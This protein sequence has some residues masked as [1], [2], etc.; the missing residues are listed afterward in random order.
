MPRDSHHEPPHQEPY[1]WLLQRQ[2]AMS[3]RQF[4]L[5]YAVLCAFSFS[6]A[7]VF[8]SMGVWQILIFT[9]VE[10]S[11]VG[12]A[13]IYHARH[14]ADMERIVLTGD[15]LLVET[16]SAGRP[17][18]I[19]L[20]PG[21]TRVVLRGRG[22]V[23]LETGRQRILVGTMVSEQRRRQCAQELRSALDSPEKNV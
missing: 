13:F 14:A 7:A 12:C 11:A 19:R 10:M 4:V 18:Y 16:L 23:A 2:C 15:C 5:A 21:R 1:I 20:D 8:I 22:Q 3:P 9:S 17:A 6:V